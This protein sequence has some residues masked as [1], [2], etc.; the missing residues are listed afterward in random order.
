MN[1]INN[2]II[3]DTSQISY[4]L[5]KDYIRISARNISSEIFNYRWNKVF[6]L[7]AEQRTIFANNILYKENFYDINYNLT[8]DIINKI[9]ANEILYLSTTELWNK[10]NGSINI[11]TPW[12]YE[13]NYYTDS[14]KKITLELQ[15]KE[16]VKIIY[17]F[18]FNSSYRSKDFL[19]GKIFYSIK[20]NEKIKLGNLNIK[21]ELLHANYVANELKKTT[22][23]RI[24]G[25]GYTVDIKNFIIDIYNQKNL[26]FN[27][28][29]EFKEYE[30]NKNIFFLDNKTCYTYDVLLKDYLNDL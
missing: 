3:G 11:N 16:N 26:N 1:I 20:N 25:S 13:E 14:K 17:P 8:L 24:I 22:E 5:P 23:S 29:V 27:E 15:K 10:C 28:L 4:Y 12:N 19:F 7:F 21:R 30:Y 6:I 2:L 9:N 18:N